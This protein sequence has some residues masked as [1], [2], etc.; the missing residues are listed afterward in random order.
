MNR[1][2]VIEA[3]E[4]GMD[5]AEYI[6]NGF[7]FA[8]VVPPSLNHSLVVAINPKV[9]ARTDKPG[10]VLTS[11]SKPTASAH[12]ISLAPL[13][14][15]QPR[16]SLQALHLLLMTMVIPTPKLASENTLGLVTA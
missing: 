2:G 1:Y 9:S 14:V 13:R 12:L 8:P 10:E 11:N 15:C 4:E 16:M 5:L 3:F 6:V 7:N